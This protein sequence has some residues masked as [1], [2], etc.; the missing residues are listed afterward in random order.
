MLSSLHLPCRLEEL[1][2]LQLLPA[3]VS[4]SAK[5]A[6]LKEASTL[7]NRLLLRRR[8]EA[9][10]SDK[11]QLALISAKRPLLDFHL[12]PLQQAPPVVSLSGSP[13]LLPR[14]QPPLL[15]LLDLASLLRLHRLV[16]LLQLTALTLLHPPRLVL[17][18]A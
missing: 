8:L 11:L 15:Q 5:P 16:Q 9:L 4:P 3:A 1:L 18:L 2:R 10:I 14:A 12:A 13:L 17:A 6:N 7:G